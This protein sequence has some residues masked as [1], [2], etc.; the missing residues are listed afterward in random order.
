MN[1]KIDALIN[2]YMQ[3]L[4]YFSLKKTSDRSRAEELT[5]E[6]ILEV[7]KSLRNGNHPDDF[8]AWIWKIARNRY[9]RWAQS[10]REG[11]CCCDIYELCEVI[12]DNT[13]VS[14]DV[15]RDEELG[16]LYRELALLRYDYNKIITEY[17]FRNRSL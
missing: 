4:F 3:P 10:Q 6:I 5:Q 16:L 11:R 14:D 1:D 9:A 15:I 2:E 12:S 13:D 7:I 8:N 17:Y